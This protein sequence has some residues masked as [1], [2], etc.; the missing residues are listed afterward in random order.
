MASACGG[1][2]PAAPAG[3]GRMVLNGNTRVEAGFTAILQATGILEG[4]PGQVFA[5][6]TVTFESADTTIARVLRTTEV[7]N[8]N[9]RFEARIVTFRPGTVRIDVRS[10][11][12]GDESWE[13]TVAPCPSC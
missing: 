12:A 7:G 5:L 13:L 11:R 6:G 9:Q 10:S 3:V 8:F 2:D 1:E 4:G